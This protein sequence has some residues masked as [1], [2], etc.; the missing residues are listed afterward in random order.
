MA[1]EW[2]QHG[3]NINNMA[4]YG[5]VDAMVLPRYCHVIAPVAAIS[6]QRNT[7]IT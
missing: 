4:C 5:H 7:A 3:N 2:Q 6:W 1:I